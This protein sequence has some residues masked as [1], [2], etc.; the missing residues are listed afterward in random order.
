MVLLEGGIP[1]SFSVYTVDELGHTA[2]LTV[3]PPSSTTAL[4]YLSENM[5]Y[6]Y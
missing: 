5:P 1:S 4:I 6:T 3:L 2:N